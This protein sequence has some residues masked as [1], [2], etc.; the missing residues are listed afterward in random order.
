MAAGLCVLWGAN[1]VAIK[2]TLSGLGPCT[3]AAVRFGLA[4]AML[5]AWSAATGARLRPAAGEL[6]PLILNSLLFAFQ[7]AL[8]YI[9]F[10][11]T[12][13][14]RGVLLINLQP[15]FL[16]FI[17]HFFLRGDRITPLKLAGLAI[18][19]A[20]AACVFLDRAGT[21][22]GALAGDLMILVST[23]GWAA[24]AAYTKHLI[25]SISSLKIVFTQLLF[26]LPVFALG[27]AL[28]DS[29][30]VAGVT[31]GVVAAL[32]FQAAVTT[33]FAFLA[34]NRLLIVHGAVALHAFVFLIPVSGV[35]LAGLFLGEALNAMILLALLLIAGGILIV[36]LGHRRE[37]AA[38]IPPIPP[39][40]D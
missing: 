29:P 23:V 26:S 20:G 39:R 24:G 31:A 8:V 36:Q 1:A 18:G 2:F 38:A 14:S 33:C 32:L 16:L 21:A 35:L 7:L 30:A 13:A 28:W 15:F 19:F 9:G 6:G 25:Q 11:F 17:A 12:N 3:A 40:G 27:A 5:A 22:S 37:T 10:T 34:W 4:A